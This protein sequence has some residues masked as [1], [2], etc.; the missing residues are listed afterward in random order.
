[1]VAIAVCLF[2]YACTIG[3]AAIDSYAQKRFP[4]GRKDLESPKDFKFADIY[5]FR[6]PYWLLLS[7][8]WLT[9]MTIFP[10]FSSVPAILQSKYQF[11]LADAGF[12]TSLLVATTVI[13]LP[14]LGF[15]ID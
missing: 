14:V 5:S 9:L 15:W 8:S 6:L 10:Y 13:I 12:Y 11:S 2:S 3:V 1:M 7:S 4:Q